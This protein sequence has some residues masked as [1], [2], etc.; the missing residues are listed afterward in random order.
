MSDN[1][2]KHKQAKRKSIRSSAGIWLC[3]TSLFALA[4]A[5]TPGVVHAQAWTGA[6][7][8]DW[9]TANN[10]NPNFLPV[11]LADIAIS[12]AKYP[13]ID[14]VAASVGTVKVGA[15]PL[16][17]GAK[18]QLD[19]VN[20]GKLS[21]STG[22]I[23][24]LDKQV[25]VVSVSGPGSLWNNT[26]AM[27]VGKG[28]AGDLLVSGGGQ[29]K[30]NS[31]TVAELVGTGSTLSVDGA[32]SKVTSAGQLMIGMQSAANM[33]VKNGGTVSN[34][35]AE[36][37]QG[38]G[39]HGYA[40]ITGK[41]SRWDS[42]GGLI[43]GNAGIATLEVSD[44]GQIS[45]L[46]SVIAADVGSYTIAT[47]SGSGSR[48]DTTQF[49]K[50]G[51]RGTAYL[52]IEQ[53]AV[54][55]SAGGHLGWEGSSLGKVDIHDAGSRW[56]NTGALTVG[57]SAWG[58][59]YVHD[60]AAITSLDGTIAAD[61]G[62]TGRV[63]VTK[64]AS[65]TMTDGL[66]VAQ[67]GK[68]R[69][70]V[71]SGGQVSNKTA[72]I[73]LK[74]GAKG[75]VTVQDAGSLW[76]SS[77][78]LTV[79][80]V[81]EG[82]LQVLDGGQVRSL[83][84]VVASDAGGV[85]HVVVSGA[86]S[87]WDNTQT[88]TVGVFGMGEMAVLQGAAVTNTGGRIGDG[89]GS[90]GLVS[91]EGAGSTWKNTGALFVGVM[92]QGTLRI[93]EG[94]LVES[95][96][97]T[98]GF[99]A[100]GK[101]RVEIM[102]DVYASTPARWINVGDLVVGNL[103]DGTLALRTS[104]QLTVTGGDIVIAQQTGSTGKLI[105]GTEFGE[106][107]AGQVTAPRIRFG[108]GAGALVFNHES[109][110]YVFAT[111]IQGKGVIA[112]QQGSTIYTG[113]GS[114]FTGTT[115]VSGGTLRVNGTLGGTVDVQSGG[116][117]GGTGFLGGAVTVAASGTLLGSSGQTLTMGSL[118]LN[119]G[120]NVNVALGAPGNATGL[121][122]VGGNLTLAGMLNVADAGGFGQ[123]VYRIFDYAGAL[124][125]NG[126]TVGTLPIGTG[127]IQTAMA[128][129]VNLVVDS[130]SPVP[131][132]L[133]W[134]GTTTVADGT[135]HGGN[136]T[137][138]AGPAT[139]WT[140]VNG[141]VAS[142]WAGTFAVFQNNPGNV[143]VDA[144]AGMVSATGMQFIGTGWTV[145]G[146]PITLNG[147][148]GNTA[149]RVGDGTLGGAAYRATIGSELTGNS[150]LVKDD[151]G[152]LILTGAN[153]YTGGTTIAAGTLQIGNGSMVGSIAGD[154]LN[155]G[156]LAFNRSDDL[157]FAGVVGGSGSLRQ[158]GAGTVV[159][160]GNSGGFT[161]TTR[162]ESGTLAVNGQLGGSVAV[163][164][165]GALAGI[166]KVGT[167]S[168]AN[169]GTLS[170]VQGQTLTIGG[171]TLTAGSNV[172]VALGM[173]GNAAGLFK[174]G[175]NLT[176][177][178]MLNVADAGGFGQGV[179]R[180][181]DYSGVLTDNGMTVGTLPIGTGTLQTAMANQVNLVVD[182]GGPV[183]AMEFWNGTTTVADGAIHGGSGI[184]SA[185]PATNWTGANG[186][187]AS[188]WSGTFAVFQNNP[189]N[190]TVDA[191]AGAVSATG[192]QFI[193]TGWTVAGDP[194]T[195][196][197]SGGSTM[198][199][200]G[201]G[202]MAGAGFTATIASALTGTSR[203]VKGDLGVL[204][205][206]GTNTYAGGTTI[207][208]GTLQ[209][210]NG[211][212]TGSIVGNVANNG[213]LAFNRSNDLTVAGA[214]TG[215]GTLRQIG[216]GTTMLTGDSSGFTGT[217]RVENGVLSVNGK[218]GGTLTVLAGGQLQGIGA[219]GDVSVFGT[220][221]PGNSIGTLTVANITFQ[222]G[223]IYQVEVNAGGQSDKI[224][225]TGT[226]TLGGGSVQVLAGA[227]NYQ[228][229]TT[230]TILTAA[231]GRTGT[232]NNV[233][234]NL[235]FLAPSLSYDPDNVYLTLTRNT[236][237]FP[238]VGGTFNQRQAGAGVE[239][240]SQGN[241]IWNAVV[242]MDA[243]TAQAAFNQLS[244]EVHASAKTALY[245]D[246]RLVRDGALSRL[247]QAFGGS[248]VAPSTAQVAS[249]E[250]SCS[251]EACQADPGGLG[252]AAWAQGFGSWGYT[253]GDGNAAGLSRSTG[254]VLVG[255][256]AAVF[257]VARLGL[258][259]GYSHTNFNVADRQSS[260]GSDNVHLGA[261]GGAQWGPIGVRAGLAYTWHNLS[262]SRSVA[263]PGFAD[264]LRATYGAGTFQVFGEAGYRVEVGQAAFEPFANIAYMSLSTKGFS[265]TGGAAAL[266]STG[267]T[268]NVTATTLGLR[269]GSAFVVAGVTGQARGT[270][271]W[272]HAFTDTT[273]W[274]SLQLAGGTPF[275]A[276]GVPIARD[277]AL[278]ELGIDLRLSE[279][280]SIGISYTG[281][282]ASG[283]QDQS[284]RA[285]FNYKL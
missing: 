94:G 241:P 159:L 227:G 156:T 11:N 223:S 165:G 109:A 270:V 78:A 152:T 277:A 117:L 106:S 10:W 112:H 144:S 118:A 237:S 262:T 228:S 133:F 32:G 236:V 250:E 170:G 267:L 48:W 59:L 221:A 183:P 99:G 197:G 231:G 91:V 30:S 186:A 135:I 172:N 265:E 16:V 41:D 119:A 12:T 34:G 42:S 235:A 70:F 261:Y 127:T 22:V 207:A 6:T 139:N 198:I 111:T 205:L 222:P 136:G 244:G 27:A 214:I 182:T 100:G 155:N 121:F 93:A 45:S 232:F 184:W 128:N 166:G 52:N 264:S 260:G 122:K 75:E 269:A 64:G 193:G 125:D 202:T 9:L 113:N 252:I 107:Y 26:G 196:N 28:G 95:A 208:A 71:T 212:T 46:Y 218:L 145:A 217:T 239:S 116:T 141:T 18:A 246:S 76:T 203:L 105:I 66:T 114:A 14:G 58:L 209:I 283:A 164:S 8:Q 147:A 161:G 238:S 33:Y 216:S 206:T 225:A 81:G 39:T 40:G 37:A 179:Y 204:I 230:Y 194:I 282:F 259:G 219:V 176:L 102:A 143:T 97:A 211:G 53:G 284:V 149:L 266:T 210:G 226:A 255:V 20:G 126:M 51:V 280:A 162:V 89:A 96:G 134:N 104:S 67:S 154:V 271:G 160:T 87:R 108:S 79:A 256:D 120:S 4:G 83:K 90:N 3:S 31:I 130:G 178:G 38:A 17:P 242:Q 1:N 110:D 199:R 220:I 35:Y 73:A 142:A 123:G 68:G 84:G 21:S 140:D 5:M 234:S 63:D 268:N 60:G 25:G 150:R 43:V 181:F 98:I 131:T 132:V 158:I 190:I 29:V 168:V 61:L 253:S 245:E 248:V 72:V 129:Q 171:L 281:Q 192:M 124:T 249:I 275:T 195:L 274:A 254:G 146:D 177:A 55:T 50:V 101:G 175:G 49:L 88:L 77:A 243:P 2:H 138:S 85:G 19:I 272:Q 180:I 7:S 163:L 285:A 82:S 74:A 263:F 86:G 187:T 36:I 69:L 115:T 189:G 276:A 137:W 157:T 92:G 23:A 188:P 224:V 169:G 151:L 279:R 215:S 200:V 65:W 201:D 153:S 24:E 247:R 13:I 54:V 57:L 233:T 167:V 62:S 257:E 258:F 240:L 213:T 80:A 56:D 191:S 173:P 185:G 251:G 103:G 44:A 229:N 47:V 273:P 15:F 174:V 148:G 278:L